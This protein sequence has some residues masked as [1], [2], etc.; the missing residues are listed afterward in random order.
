[1]VIFALCMPIVVLVI[2]GIL[3]G[4]QPASD[5]ASHTFLSQS[6][7][8]VSLIA[9]AAGGL[10]G[11]PL[12]LSDYREKKILKRFKVT[13]V[14]PVLLLAVQLCIYLIYALLSLLSLFIIATLFFNFKIEGS[15]LAFLGGYLL[16]TLSL[17]SIGLMVGGIAKDSKKAGVI[18]SL[19]YFPML[20]FSGATLPYEVMPNLMQKIVEVL[21]MTQG[22]KLLKA[23]TMGIPIDHILIPLLSMSVILVICTGIAIKHFKWES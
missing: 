15:I 3:Y 16:V 11:L 5:G 1:M 20:V 9:V 19:L 10:M 18:A 21:P 23:I 6:F 14:S 8:A 2:L 7:A 17:F 12:V 13:P 22:I 4:N